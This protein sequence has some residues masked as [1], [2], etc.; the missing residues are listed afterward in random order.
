M[1]K[2]KLKEPK[3]TPLSE[4]LPFYFFAGFLLVFLYW[5][6]AINPT[7]NG[8]WATWGAASSKTEWIVLNTAIFAVVGVFSFFEWRKSDYWEYV[9]TKIYANWEYLE[10]G[11]SNEVRK[12]LKT[13]ANPFAN[14]G[15]KD[16]HAKL[17]YFVDKNK[18]KHIAGRKY[19]KKSAWNDL[20]K[21]A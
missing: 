1:S 12:L 6:I 18:G 21:V 4:R 19:M 15:A 17:E 10:D 20:P 3:R 8:N 2:Y 7:Q 16:A 5:L 9:N 13:T 11:Q 14:S